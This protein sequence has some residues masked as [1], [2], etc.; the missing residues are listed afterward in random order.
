MEMICHLD[1]DI[2]S[3]VDKGIKDVEVRVNDEKRRKLNIGD[4]VIFINRGNENETLTTTILS[5][6]Y[7]DNFE[8]LVR[9]YDIERMYTK[10]IT[11]ED[12]VKL[13]E[14]FYTKEEQEEYGV[15]ALVLKK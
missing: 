9:H 8:E 14:R 7:Y 13:L 3:L 5:L 2:Y 4:N 12:F 10:D 15:V 6:D 11:K 1:E